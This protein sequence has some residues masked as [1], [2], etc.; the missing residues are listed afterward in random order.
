[1]TILAEHIESLRKAGYEVVSSSPLLGF[2]VVKDPV[3]CSSGQKQWIEHIDVELSSAEEIF[4]FI[5]ERS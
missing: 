3:F 5:S 4:R 2:V 1:M